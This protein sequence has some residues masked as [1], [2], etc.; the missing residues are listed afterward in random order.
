[1]L[2]DRKLAIIH[3]HLQQIDKATRQ[4]KQA[5][6]D[7]ISIIHQLIPIRCRCEVD[8]YLSF[9]D[10]FSVTVTIHIQELDGDTI[11]I[12]QEIAEDY[13]IEPEDTEEVRIK[14]FQFKEIE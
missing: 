13:I 14:I 5:K 9:H 6:L 1:M 11:Q 2:S 4:R 3:N 10:D 7:L 8:Y 12:I